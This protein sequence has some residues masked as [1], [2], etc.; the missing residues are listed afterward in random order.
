[1]S[2]KRCLAFALAAILPLLAQA[3]TLNLK[4]EY[5]QEYTVQKGDTLWKISS[6]FLQSPWLWPQLWDENTDLNDPHLIYPGDKLKLVFVDGK[7][8]LVRKPVIK[9]APQIRPQSK[10]DRAIPTIPLELIHPFLTRDYIASDDSLSKAPIILGNNQGNT[11]FLTGHNFF[12]SSSLQRGQYGIY[13]SGRQYIDPDTDEKLGNEVVFVG[14]AEVIDSGSS[15]TPAKLEVL[16][17]AKEA[18]KGDRLLPM[19][20][21]DRLPVYFQPRKFQLTDTGDIIAGMES[22]G[23]IGRNDVVLINRGWRNNV[24]AGDMFSVLRPGKTIVKKDPKS[25][26][27]YEETAN[28][29]DKVFA[30][31][32]KLQLPDEQ[33]G[34]MMVFKV[35]DKVSFALITESKQMITLNDKVGNL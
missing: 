29:Y 25:G 12:V 21:Q 20:Q 32:S 7:P 13:R 18:R 22:R 16:Q 14:I 15:T 10:K 23:I 3:D 17:S 11:T 28:N 24:S 19:T 35:Y 30:G 34:E 2:V 33:V 1:M 9:M 5:P 26:L 6:K 31:Q 4:K 27:A 8:R